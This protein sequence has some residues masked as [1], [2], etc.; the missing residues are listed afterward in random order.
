MFYFCM[1]E[2]MTAFSDV[3]L[4]SMMLLVDTVEAVKCVLREV[5]HT[6]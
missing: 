2:L 3:V 5:R 4:P 1:L 6:A